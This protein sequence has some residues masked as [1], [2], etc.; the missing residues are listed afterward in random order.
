MITQRKSPS[1]MRP[2][3]FRKLSARNSSSRV[4]PDNRWKPGKTM[5]LAILTR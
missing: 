4:R 3:S 2:K 5:F 1:R